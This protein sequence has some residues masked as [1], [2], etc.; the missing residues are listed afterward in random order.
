MTTGNRPAKTIRVGAVKATVWPRDRM[1]NGQSY[2]AYNVVLDR[3]YKDATGQFQRTG[4]LDLNSIPKAILA[5]KKAYEFLT[6][7][8]GQTE[9]TSVPMGRYRMP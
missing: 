4:S 9:D 3:T 5:L 2:T 7:T 8:G 6:L 1:S